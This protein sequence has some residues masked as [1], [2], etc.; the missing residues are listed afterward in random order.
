MKM[1]R[2]M[3]APPPSAYAEDAAAPSTSSTASTTPA[4]PSPSTPDQ[5]D[6]PSDQSRPVADRHALRR[7]RWLCIGLGTLF[8]FVVWLSMGISTTYP[9]DEERFIESARAFAG[10]PSLEFLRTYE[11]MSGPLPFWYW[12]NW[13]QLFGDSLISMRLATMVWGVITLWLLF[14]VLASLLPRPRW[15]AIAFA[16]VILNPYWWTMSIFAYTDI[17]GMAGLLL[18]SIGVVRG[19]SWWDVAYIVVGLAVALLSRQYLVFALPAMGIV[20]LSW[21]AVDRRMAIKL[22]GAI[23]VGCLPLIMLVLLWRGLGPDNVL[24]D[25]YQTG[26]LRWKFES[27]WLY[28]CLMGIYGLP[29]W[30]WLRKVATFRRWEWL[31][32]VIT[33]IVGGLVFITPSDSAIAVGFTTVGLFDRTMQWLGLIDSV[34][35]LIWTL[36]GV[37]GVLLLARLTTRAA[38]NITQGRLGPD[39]YILLILLGVLIVMPL[40]YLHWEKYFIPAL[41]WLCAGI[42]RL[43]LAARG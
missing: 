29:L 11:E 42:V 1:P 40:S 31:L 32:A 26:L 36:G 17:F 20:A 12:G 6:N 7:V 34:R 5:P 2:W 30:V 10:L 8:L 25:T 28:L 43:K 41:P 22:L 9:G 19:R 16:C 35:H 38:A 13:G 24:K 27:A 33:L 39:T 3:L 4:S 21:W 15:V 23:A 18:A 14:E 37:L